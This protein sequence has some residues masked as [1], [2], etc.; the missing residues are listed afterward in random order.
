MVK[1]Q[2]FNHVLDNLLFGEEKLQIRIGDCCKEE[3]MDLHELT[4]W[5]SIEGAPLFNLPGVV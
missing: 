4:V 3:I 5:R 2:V 1:E